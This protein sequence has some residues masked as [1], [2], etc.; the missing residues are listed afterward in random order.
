MSAI[1][2]YFAG[3]NMLDLMLRLFLSA[4]AGALIGYERESRF[5]E[6]GIK[7][8]L[9]VCLGSALFMVI[10]KHGFD[11]LSGSTFYRV[12]ASRIA[13]QVV[14]GIGFLG[15]GIIFVRKHTVQGL[16]TAAGV[17]TTSGIGLAI[18]GGMYGIGIFAML[19]VIFFQIVIYRYAYELRIPETENLLLK[20]RNDP[21]ALSRTM[22]LLKEKKIKV[23]NFRLEKMS[24]TRTFIE[25][26]IKLPANVEPVT[27]LTLL[28]QSEDV[29][30]VSF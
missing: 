18:G 24:E 21:E 14:S 6:A 23:A 1:V 28:N 4:I 25:L 9:I 16:T 13:A 30:S 26:H 15:A 12:D 2:N 20:L 8:H 22:E 29:L 5:K 17:W 11:D 7:T 27:L 3:T 19:L 10:S